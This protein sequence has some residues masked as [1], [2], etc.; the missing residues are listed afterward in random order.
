MFRVMNRP[1]AFLAAAMLLFSPANW[2]YEAPLA[3]RSVR[4]AYFL[5]QRNNEDT[6]AF[7]QMYTKHFTMP[8]RG[9]YISEIRLLTPYAQVV[10]I[11][12]H[13]TVGYSAQQAQAEYKA[14][15]DSLLVRVRI[16]F[17]ATYNDV[18][19]VKPTKND[20]SQP[21]IAPRPEDF[22]KDFRF[23]LSQNGEDLQYRSISGEPQYIP[24]EGLIN[25][26][27]A[28]AYVNLV[29]DVHTVSS[30][31]TQVEVFSPDG[32]RVAASFDLA[33]LR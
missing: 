3:S 15:G 24:E 21:N 20:G 9:P 28:G 13:K 33:A 29:Y 27:L 12:R 22:W 6:K 16:D 30:R 10:D 26:V 8:P 17:T 14:R 25:G 32:Q 7:L 4:D 1:A 2:A 23:V 19:T 31:K 5:G 18:M 11:A